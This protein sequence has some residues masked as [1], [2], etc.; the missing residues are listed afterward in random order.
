MVLRHRL[1]PQDANRAATN[2]RATSE[3]LAHLGNDLICGVAMDLFTLAGLGWGYLDKLQKYP[4]GYPD[5]LCLRIPTVNLILRLVYTGA[6]SV[7]S[8][9]SLPVYSDSRHTTNLHIYRWFDSEVQRER[10]RPEYAA[11]YTAALDKLFLVT[12]PLA[13]LEAEIE[14]EYRLI[15]DCREPPQSLPWVSSIWD[16]CRNTSQRQVE[17]AVQLWLAGSSWDT[18]SPERAKLVAEAQEAWEC[19]QQLVE[20]GKARGELQMAEWALPEGDEWWGA[21]LDC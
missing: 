4:K 14:E 11:D 15:K 20:D 13:K 5:Y 3:H 17:A 2:N 1:T 21:E 8:G 12:L 16:W 9:R 6:V 7:A 19:A 18:Q 10:Q